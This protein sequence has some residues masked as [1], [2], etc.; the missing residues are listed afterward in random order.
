MTEQPDAP[1]PGNEQEPGQTDA[2]FPAESVESLSLETTEGVTVP[3]EYL[4]NL[5][6]HLRLHGGTEIEVPLD[7]INMGSAR[8]QRRRGK[9]N[10]PR[11]RARFARCGNCCEKLPL[12]GDPEM[13]HHAAM[14]HKQ[15]CRV[16]TEPASFAYN[17]DQYMQLVKEHAAQPMQVE[18]RRREALQLD[19]EARL[20][21]PAAIPDKVLPWGSPE[22]ST[23]V[24]EA[25]EEKKRRRW[26][27]FWRRG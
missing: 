25:A 14:R 11:G 13:D 26:W 15:V 12:S 20:K 21:L 27:Q 17:R 4:R 10:P 6:L 19:A 3:A 9:H 8:S 2:K 16:N 1:E 7:E 23:C 22:C 24:S 18:F 5:K